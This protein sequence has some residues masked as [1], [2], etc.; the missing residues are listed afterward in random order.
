MD[1]L[2]IA[3]YT[4]F[5]DFVAPVSLT[6]QPQPRAR[7]QVSKTGKASVTFAKTD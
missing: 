3:L 1:K 5:V 2:C 4:L 6:K 7:D